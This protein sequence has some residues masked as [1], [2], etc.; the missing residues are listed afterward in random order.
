MR[1]PRTL[2]LLL[3]LTALTAAG[4]YRRYMS[5]TSAQ[6]YRMGTESRPGHRSADS[7]MVCLTILA[8]RYRAQMPDSE[9]LLCAKA[10]AAMGYIFFFRYFDYPKAM[11]NT[12]RALEIMEE[13]GAELPEAY[14][15]AGQMPRC[16]RWQ[17]RLLYTIPISLWV[18]PTAWAPFPVQL[19]GP[20]GVVGVGC[21]LFGFAQGA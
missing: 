18:C 5:L 2:L 12:V 8:N 10:R 1:P 20:W 15:T 13:A 9:K 16:T 11:E 7:A 19:R 21:P 3:C 4:S 17:I 6:L 14:L